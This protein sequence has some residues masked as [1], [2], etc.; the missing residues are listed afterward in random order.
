MTGVLVGTI[1][2]SGHAD[3]ANA[4]PQSG[5]DADPGALRTVRSADASSP[6][7]LGGVAS[8]AAGLVH[9]VAAGSH[10][11]LIGL[12]RLFGLL[13][14]AQLAAG[15]L[16]MTRRSTRT[17]GPAAALLLVNLGAVSGWLVTRFVGISRVGGLEQPSSPGLADS[18]AAALAF[19]A[20]L[21]AAAVLARRDTVTS[22]RFPLVGPAILVGVLMVPAMVSA[23]SHRHD[24]GDAGAH[25]AAGHDD[26]HDHGDGH[27]EAGGHGHAD[28]TTGPLALVAAIVDGATD[29]AH[30]DAD[31]AHGD[32]D[33]ADTHDEGDHAAHADAGHPDD[34]HH[35]GE[36]TAGDGA[37]ASGADHDDHGAHDAHADWPRP[38]DPALPFD[39][40]GVP[41]VGFAQEARA[42]ALLEETI[43]VLP[44]FA[45]VSTL[46]E[47]GYRSIGDERTGFEHFINTGYI[48]DDHFLDPEY[49]ESLVFRVDGPEPTDRTLVSAMFIARQRA[50]DDP[51][52]V[53]YGGPLMQWHVHDNLCWGLDEDGVPKVMAVTDDNGGACPPGTVLAGGDNPMVHVWITPHECGPFAA[54]E[55]HGA[56]QVADGVTSRVDQ[57]SHDH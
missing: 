7:L 9:G 52:L 35:G 30:G 5:R 3:A 24:H 2:D 16:A 39:L 43:L 18:L 20:C 27:D 21:A 45:D 1:D 25:G 37:A 19:L 22:P 29:H 49:P 51:E 26:G 55:G 33:H 15:V 28:D 17:A 54:L 10:D 32:A 34:D 23:S 53:D 57:C 14:I 31:H 42:R 8:A 56:G 4:A 12:A 41:G 50:V 6:L 11:D 38:W 40:S 48:G 44:R 36:D 13:A 47:L 46:G